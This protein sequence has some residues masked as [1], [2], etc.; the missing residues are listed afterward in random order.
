MPRLNW[1]TL[2]NIT[3]LI[4]KSKLRFIIPVILISIFKLIASMW[5]YSKSLEDG[6]FHTRWM[7]MLG[8][9]EPRWL[10]LFTAWDTSW[11]V[12]LAHTPFTKFFSFERTFFPAYPIFIRLFGILVDNYWLSAF[13]LSI[14][15]GL[16][17][18][19]IFQAIAEAY[20]SRSE[21]L[22]GTI[23][24]SF[25]P[26]IFLFTTVAY[27]E[28]LFLIAVLA[29][30]FFYL[31]NRIFY[32]S[33]CSMVAV[34][35]KTYGILIV[36]PMFIDLIIR[37]NWKGAIL[38]LTPALIIS[39]I[40]LPFTHQDL[41]ILLA[42]EINTAT[43]AVTRESLGF[44]WLRDYIV[45]IFTESRP[46]A[47]FHFFHAFALAFVILTGYLAI[48]SAKTDWRLGIYS[49]AMFTIIIIFGF[50]NGLPRYIAFIFPIWLVVRVKNPAILLPIIFL[51]Y[52]HSLILW[53]QFLWSPY[54]I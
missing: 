28:S 38:A 12:T 11:Y 20:M 34:L 27:P 43:W 44:F 42:E 4:F 1:S 6:V 36:L 48:N 47:F 49:I 35:T 33:L 17:S 45:P 51:F 31:K 26:Y 41:L 46:M 14:I 37:R 13:M 29:T 32:A 16:A 8:P 21:A 25:F 2:Q 22:S 52:I 53:Y 50:V 40:V 23:L 5:I 18:F 54:P 7:D 19:P 9:V 30:W 24:M 15:L 3:E 10:Y 39:I